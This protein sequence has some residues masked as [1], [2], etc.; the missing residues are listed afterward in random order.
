MKKIKRQIGFGGA[1]ITPFAKR[2]VNQVLDSGRLSYGSF[3]RKF[4][5]DF[6]ELSQRKFAISANSGTSA[7][8]VTIHALKEIDGWKDGDEILVPA[9]TFIASS[10]VVLQ[11][12][13]VPVFVDVDP[14]M[15]HIDH[16]KIEEKITKKTRAIMPVHLFGI[17]CDMEPILMLA[18]K[19]KL[20]IIEDSCEAMG[21]KHRGHPVGSL[22]DVACFSTYMAH[23]VTTGVGGFATTNDPKIA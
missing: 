13:L 4:E 18:K 5:E 9:I 11:N 16:K 19:Y 21:V 15:Y 10:N 23:L 12:N 17:S 2:L 22:G 6:A 7:L 1:I 3:W 14:R 8:Q 20:R